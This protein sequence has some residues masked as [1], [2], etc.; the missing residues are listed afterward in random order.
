MKR[1]LSGRIGGVLSLAAG[2]A[3]LWLSAGVL[4]APYVNNDGYQYVDAASNASAGEC[5]CTNLAHFDEQTASG[6]FPVPF[7]HFAPG[8][9]LLIAALSAVGVKAPLAGYVISAGAFLIVIWL[10]WDLGLQLGAHPFLIAVFSLLWIADESALLYAATVG[11]EAAFTAAFMALAALMVRDLA[12]TNGK[13]HLLLGAGAA[14]GVSYWL[15]YAGL[16]LVPV[17]ALYIVWRCW[18]LRSLPNRLNRR[19]YAWGAAGLAAAGILTFSVQVRNIVDSGSWRGGFSGGTRH[20]LREILAPLIRAFYHLIFGD[21]VVARPDIWTALVLVCALAACFFLYQAWRRRDL[22]APK[23]LPLALAWLSILASAYVAGIILAAL[24]SIAADF[25]RY[26]APLYPLLLAGGAAITSLTATPRQFIAVAGMAAA[27]LGIETRS[28]V[29]SPPP[30]P[31]LIASEALSQ[32]VAP[33]IPAV[34]WLRQ[35]VPASGALVAVNGQAVHYLL[36]R[37][38]VSVIE[39][40]YSNRPPSGDAMRSLMTRFGAAYL[41][42]FPGSAPQYLDS[43]TEN[44]FLRRLAAGSAPEWLT[45]AARSRSVAI[46]KC[47]S[48]VK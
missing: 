16:F 41:L 23:F 47:S 39:P 43:Q 27:I 25:P 48:C 11:T 20:S 38:V 8:Y 35:R 1:P 33:G 12:A 13:P 7:T 40:E 22:S 36:Q 45:L 19:V 29:L 10:I 31:H 3:A 9:P 26:L 4:G 44:P 28:L 21:R 17:A 2:V 15:R 30:P 14:A 32:D 42:V 46:Y 18:S 37:P 6:R 5:L 34:E 24:T